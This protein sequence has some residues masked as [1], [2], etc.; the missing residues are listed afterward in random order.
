MKK[1]QPYEEGT[2]VPFQTA[3][4]TVVGAAIAVE[5]NDNPTN[6]EVEAKLTEFIDAM[7]ALFMKHRGRFGF[8]GTKLVIL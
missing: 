6:E 7:E 5:R 1:C 8:G 3:M 2:P 4:H